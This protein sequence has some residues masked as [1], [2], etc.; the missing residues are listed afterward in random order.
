MT[1]IYFS[2]K[3]L[4]NCGIALK[5][6]LKTLKIFRFGK[7]EVWQ[8]LFLVEKVL[9]TFGKRYLLQEKHPTEHP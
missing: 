8:Q 4:N 5:H 3:Y 9:M 6:L 7:I 1:K 2:S